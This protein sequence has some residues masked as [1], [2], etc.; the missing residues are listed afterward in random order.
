MGVAARR[1]AESMLFGTGGSSPTGELALEL[2]DGAESRF[3]RARISVIRCSPSAMA[4]KVL[5]QVGERRG[6][7]WKLSTGSWSSDGGEVGEW[8]VS[9]FLNWICAYCDD[10]AF[11]VPMDGAVWGEDGDLNGRRRG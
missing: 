2:D 3:S 9:P 10:E 6:N 8:K 11:C 7:E 5:G 4:S 1:R